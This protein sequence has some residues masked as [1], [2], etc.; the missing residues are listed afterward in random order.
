MPFTEKRNPQLAEAGPDQ[1]Y[2][3]FE[4]TRLLE[5]A[6]QDDDAGIRETSAFIARILQ[7]KACG[8]LDLEDVVILLEGQREMALI[9][10]N[11]AQIALR[12]RIHATLI[13][14]I[15]LALTTLLKAC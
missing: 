7:E 13:R 11:N 10:A 2:L 14:L 15:D 5:Q 1:Q 12:S 6:R 9:R 4:F 8:W 3:A